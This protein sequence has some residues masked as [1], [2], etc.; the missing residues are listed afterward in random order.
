MF[1]LGLDVLAGNESLFEEAVNLAQ[2]PEDQNKE[3]RD[4]EQQELN[5]H[6]VALFMW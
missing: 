6:V 2:L 1:V 3:N 4:Y 5:V